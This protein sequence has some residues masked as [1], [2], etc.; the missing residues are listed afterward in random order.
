MEIKKTWNSFWYF[1]WKDESPK[2]WLISGIFIFILIYFII[3]PSLNFVTGTTLPLAIVESCSMYHKGNLISNFDNW[4][5]LN[6]EKYITFNINKNKFG[7]FP[8]KRGLNKGDII[9]IIGVKPEQI[10]IGDVIVFS[11]GQKNPIIHRIVN[12]QEENGKLIFSTLGD[13]NQ[14]QLE[15]EKR[16]SEEQIIG[17]AVLRPAPYLGWI[18][19][20]IFEIYKEIDGNPETRFQGFCKSTV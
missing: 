14:G 16:I 15:F 6:Q 3:F 9:F 17:K 7:E 18:K 12:I 11:A 8:L 13:N 1:V 10:K 19:L 20:I 2:G 4:W 5:T